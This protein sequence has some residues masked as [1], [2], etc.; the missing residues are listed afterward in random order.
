MLLA[1]RKVPLA[2]VI[3]VE[4]GTTN[5]D[6]RWLASVA[7]RNP[8]VLGFMTYADPLDPRLGGRLDHWQRAAKFRGVR[9]RLEGIHDANFPTTL[10]F[11]EALQLLRDRNLVAELL[12]EP[13]HMRSLAQALDRI[14]GVNAV[15]NHMAKPSPAAA[16]DMR[17]RAIWEE[18]MR[19]LATSPSTCCKLSLSLPAAD[20][21]DV[22]NAL[23]FN[24]V[25]VVASFARYAL[26]QFGS[27]R[28][29]WGSDW[30][31]SSLFASYEAVLGMAHTSL[32][33]LSADDRDAVF[34]A[35]AARIYGL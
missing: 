12:I 30:P 5:Q 25:A 35:T 31:L 2:G 20:L 16:N 34:R 32:E 28:C 7:A 6:N 29:C 27:S 4:S 9:F 23:R 24:D 18:G 14:S 3:L 19:A 11:A 33:P 26:A 15:I 13:H 1:A 17:H 21:S 8:Q 22:S 10:R